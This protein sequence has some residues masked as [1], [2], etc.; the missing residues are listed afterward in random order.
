[1]SLSLHRQE[2][3]KQKRKQKLIKFGLIVLVF[4]ILIATFSYLS[5]RPSIR[6]FQVELSGQTILDSEEVRKEVLSY[7][8]DSYFWIFPKNN[9]FL[10]PKSSLENH[11]REV[12]KRI[13]VLDLELRGF[14]TLQVKVTD[15]GLLA[16]WCDSAPVSYEEHIQNQTRQCYF[17][18]NSGTIFA[19][20]PNF[21]G[22]AYFRYYGLVSDNPIGSYYLA[23]T[24]EFSQMNALV[25][26]ARELSIHP[27]YMIPNGNKEFTLFL[28]GGGKIYF[29]TR[30]SL[31]KT[32]ENLASL[33]RATIFKF[34]QN[35]NLPV[36][37]ID[38]RFGNKLFYKL[39]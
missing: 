26:K 14:Q 20:S 24:T 2:Y 3:L 11:L 37:Y 13:D 5:Y 28:R 15:R 16:L 19:K 32:S 25:A 36:D 1:M 9:A 7:L 6:I 31:T 27:V 23:S 21:S 30:E 34:D 29:D 35:G 17:L 4:I 8:D 18:D 33:L 22:D 39:K 12:F 10:Y 38:L